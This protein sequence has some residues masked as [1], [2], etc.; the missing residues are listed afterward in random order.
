MAKPATPRATKKPKPPAVDAK[1]ATDDLSR[2]VDALASTVEAL[3]KLVGNVVAQQ[4]G[5]PAEKPKQPVPLAPL[6]D[7]SIESIMQESPLTLSGYYTCGHRFDLKFK[8]EDQEENMAKKEYR[9]QKS[10]SRCGGDRSSV[11]DQM[12][13]SDEENGERR[14][15]G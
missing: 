7:S 5:A 2:K 4:Q 9:E 13:Q 8:K 3:A 6:P 15:D 14:D 11:I 12:R 1:P 10:C